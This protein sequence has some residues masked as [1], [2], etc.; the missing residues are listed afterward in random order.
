[1]SQHGEPGDKDAVV[2]GVKFLRRFSGLTPEVI[3]LGLVSFFADVSSEMLYP[4]TPIFLTAVLGAPVFTLGLIEGAAEGTASLMRVVAGRLSDLSGRRRPYVLTGYT[5]SAIAKPLIS[6]A[7]AWSQVLFARVLDRFGKGLRTSPRDALLADVVNPAYRGQA[8]GWHRAMDTLGAVI[9]PL[10]TLLILLLLSH[11]P[12]AFFRPSPVL[13][14][15]D[16]ALLRQIFLIAFFPGIIGAAL[17]LTVRERRQAAH[18][19][20]PPIGFR[21]LPPAFRQYLLAWGVFAV[22]NSSDMFLIL[23]ANTLGLSF[24]LVV[25]VYTFY[26]IVYALSSPWLGH[27]SDVL[28]RK[29]VLAGGLLVFALV[30]LGFALANHTWQIWPLFAIYGLY[31]AATDGVGKALAVD[32]TPASIRASAI[33]LLGTVSGLAALIASTVAGFLWYSI[34]PWA[35][36]AYGAVGALCGCL[37]LVANVSESSPPDA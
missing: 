14:P 9:G 28:G 16:K 15:A 4:L 18:T 25:L 35:P 17:V 29:R 31:T 23:R 12:G 36:F 21:A 19:P 10:L 20:P 7:V 2:G 32:L 30:Y 1:M 8:F 26:N 37:L 5:L 22:A 13:A 24:F 34:A 11:N 27:L 3:R 33:G 6:V